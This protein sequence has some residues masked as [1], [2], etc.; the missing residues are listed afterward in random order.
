MQVTVCRRCAFRASRAAGSFR[1]AAQRYSGVRR[2]CLV[3]QAH[4]IGIQPRR[5]HLPPIH[6]AERISVRVEAK[7]GP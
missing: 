4:G 3:D 5:P 2:L 7:R 6:A 1:T